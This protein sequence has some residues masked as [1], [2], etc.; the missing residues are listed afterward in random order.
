MGGL[1]GGA[2]AEAEEEAGGEEGDAEPQDDLPR[3]D[4]DGQDGDAGP[5]EAH[6]ARGAVEAPAGAARVDGG[7]RVADEAGGAEDEGVRVLEWAVARGVFEAGGVEHAHV[8]ADAAGG[9]VGGGEGEAGDARRQGGGAGGVEGGEGGEDLLLEGPGDVGGGGQA[10]GG[11]DLGAGEERVGLR[12]V[13]HPLRGERVEE[14]DVLG[15]VGLHPSAQHEAEVHFAALDRL[16]LPQVV[17]LVEYHLRG[18]LR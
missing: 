16:H 14:G 12:L 9:L 1:E 7:G 8:L 4:V 6:E 13:D 5:A 11:D 15:V 2:P 3:E 18:C 17:A 10:E